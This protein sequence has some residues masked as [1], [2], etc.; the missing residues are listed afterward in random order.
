MDKTRSWIEIDEHVL[1][2][3]I[4]IIRK[5]LPQ[6]VSMIGVVKANAY[7]HGAVRVSKILY[8]NGIHHLAVATLQEGIALRRS[9][10]Q[11]EILILGF[12]DPIHAKMI[13]H[14]HLTQTIL[15]LAYAKALNACGQKIL[16]HLAI[17]TGMHRLG[18]NQLDELINILNL[19]YL[20]ITG[21][22]SHL[23]APDQRMPI[24]QAY[25]KKQIAL[26]DRYVSQL[27]NLGYRF[28]MRHLAS[29]YGFLNYPQAWYDGVRLGLC[30]YG[31]DED[32]GVM[33]VRKMG[34]RPVLSLKSRLVLL[35]DLSIGEA[36]GYGCTYRVDHPIRMGVLPIGY[37]DG[38]DRRLSN[39]GLVLL[40]GKKVPIIG[41]VCMDQ[42]MIDVSKVPDARIGD[43]VIL[44]GPDQP[45]EQMA[46]ICHTV[47]NEILTHLGTR[48]YE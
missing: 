28:S 15:D 11:G 39:R 18:T 8:E 43:E 31:V 35:R 46:S 37:A 14:Y 19:P 10:I 26:F 7:G 44:I 3:N 22:Y 23:S 33:Q 20:Q 12:T 32:E 42:M 48:L 41:R 21:V 16:C 29:S 5:Y 47:S 38:I 24:H 30:L 9:G 2:E 1:V 40:R 17:D 25:T 6:S 4:K 36:V 34:L 45:I 13:H 27:E